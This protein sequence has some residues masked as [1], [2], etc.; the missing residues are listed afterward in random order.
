MFE[1]FQGVE[2]K[3]LRGGKILFSR[4]SQTKPAKSVGMIRILGSSELLPLGKCLAQVLFGIGQ[5]ATLQF[6]DSQ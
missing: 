1:R 4:Q 6:I 5:F 3:G 2:Q